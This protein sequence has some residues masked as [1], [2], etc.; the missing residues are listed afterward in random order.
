VQ[1]LGYL[2]LLLWELGYPEQALKRSQETIARAHEL[3]YVQALV[4]A[5]SL[6]GVF[7][8]MRQNIRMAHEYGELVVHLTAEHGIVSWGAL[9]HC[10]YGWALAMQGQG[11][12]GIAQMR[13][14]I[15]ECKAIEAWIMHPFCATHLAQ[16]YGQ[17]GQTE[18]GIALLNEALTVARRNEE[19]WFDTEISRLKGDLLLA[20]GQAVADVEHTYEQ[21]IEL[22]RQRDAKSRE[23]RA[24]T[25]LCR[26]WQKQGKRE[27]GRKLLA[28][29][30]GWFTEGFDTPDLQEAKALLE[31]LR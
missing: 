31:E 30:Y 23:L 21:A 9:G 1:T 19:R 28:E 29:I 17:A 24:T 11:K 10:I 4:G 6:A 5:Y 12:E 22:A 3:G 27:A 16:V 26:L 25:S 14:G 15:A 20:Q 13:R 18:E 2:T 8:V 7:S